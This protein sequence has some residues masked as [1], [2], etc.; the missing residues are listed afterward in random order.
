[1]CTT[2]CFVGICYS[3][4]YTGSIVCML[5]RTLQIFDCYR[6]FSSPFNLSGWAG[7]RDKSVNKGYVTF[8][9]HAY[10]LNVPDS[11]LSIFVCAKPLS[12]IYVQSF[13]FRFPPA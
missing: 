7:G 11:A 9:S 13:R 5:V 12:L 10:L 8:L 1:M 2:N 4:V 6:Q 3:V